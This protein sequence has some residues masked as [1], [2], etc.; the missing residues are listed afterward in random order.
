VAPPSGPPTFS[1]AGSLSEETLTMPWYMNFTTVCKSSKATSFRMTIGCWAEE[2]CGRGH[3]AGVS[4]EEG[5]EVV[6]AGGEDHL[7][8]LQVLPLGR[9]RDVYQ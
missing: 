4:G 3:L 8:G 6:R 5:L 1:T 9:Q 2:W 7:V